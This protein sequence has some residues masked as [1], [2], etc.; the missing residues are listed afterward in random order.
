MAEN[1]NPCLNDPTLEI[2]S[3]YVTATEPEIGSAQRDAD[4]FGGKRCLG[5]RQQRGEIGPVNGVLGIL[6][7]RG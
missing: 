5:M 1:P 3:C 7:D 6:R 2:A 4:A